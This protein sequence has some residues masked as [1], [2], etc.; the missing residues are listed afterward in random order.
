MNYK[1][2]FLIRLGYLDYVHLKYVNTG[3]DC[4]GCLMHPDFA[5]EYPRITDRIWLELITLLNINTSKRL[6]V[7]DLE[8]LKTQTLKGLISCH[9]E[10]GAVVGGCDFKELQDILVE[11]V[12]ALFKEG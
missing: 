10:M 7:C 3:G 1:N 11:Q 2:S 9:S 8:D 5:L 12:Q 6:Y 4:E